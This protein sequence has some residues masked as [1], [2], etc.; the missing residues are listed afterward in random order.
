[1]KSSSLILI[2]A[3]S[4]LGRVDVAYGERYKL[5]WW[6]PSLQYVA[7]DWVSSQFSKARMHEWMNE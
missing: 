1:M 3:S 7:D 2:I 5:P 6:H 4:I